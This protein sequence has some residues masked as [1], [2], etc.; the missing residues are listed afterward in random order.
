MHPHTPLLR[1]HCAAVL[2]VLA[3]AAFALAPRPA[4]A[5]GSACSLLKAAD[6]AGLVGGTPVNKATPEGMV[7]TWTG[8]KAGKKVAILT[9][10]NRGV[11]PD[12]AFQ[13]ARHS[14]QSHAEA[15]VQDEAGIGERA[16]SGQVPFGAV[17]VV[18]KKGKVFQVQ[19]WTGAKGTSQD[20]TALRPIARKA[21]AAF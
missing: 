12:A 16:F 17:F 18:L 13:G 11:P 15:N 7:C 3:C 1:S 10:K 9:Y 2:A 14:I 21:A 20:V 19:Y 8:A 4:A 5:Q 6:V